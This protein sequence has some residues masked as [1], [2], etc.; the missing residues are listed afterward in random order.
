MVT[1]ESDVNTG[2]MGYYGEHTHFWHN[3]N[4]D[5][6]QCDHFLVPMTMV[7]FPISVFFLIVVYSLTVHCPYPL[8]VML[9][10]ISMVL[11]NRTIMLRE[12]YCVNWNFLAFF[13]SWN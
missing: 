5:A 2:K 3:R 8:C 13:D 11:S 1:Q 10:R 9:N 7:T 4:F 6:W 12:E